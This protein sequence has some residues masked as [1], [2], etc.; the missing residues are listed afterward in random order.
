MTTRLGQRE[1]ELLLPLTAGLMLLAVSRATPD[2]V[3]GVLSLI[4][5]FALGALVPDRP[6]R[7]GAIAASPTVAVAVLVAAAAGS[8][9]SVVV[10]VV[11]SPLL[12]AFA[13]LLVRGGAL[14]GAR[15]AV[16]CDQGRSEQAW[17]PFETKAQR[18]R[19]LVIVA[20]IVMVGSVWMS[21]WGS[22]EVDRA[23]AR[24]VEHIRSS[25]AGRTPESV[26]VQGVMGAAA[27]ESQ[28]PGG[29]YRGA[30]LGKDR[31][32]AT[33]EVS[34]G[35]QSRCIHVVLDAEGEVS[36]RVSHGRCGG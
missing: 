8:V 7:T 2:G 32:T 36:T 9:G 1:A 28:L 21:N 6:W 25:L 14:L 33:A 20:T 35:L 17:R 12:V 15:D 3:A 11:C 23:A 10:F 5:L 13:A 34:K 18:G 19:F 4:S 31:F 26:R 16:P 24:R 30:G 27:G 22:A 29:P